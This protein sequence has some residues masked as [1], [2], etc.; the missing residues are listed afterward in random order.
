MSAP[1]LSLQNITY[2]LGGRPLLDGAELGVL[3]GE[4]I[5]LVGRNGSGK[6]T[7]LKIASGDIVADSGSRFVQPGIKVHY[8]AQEPDLSRYATTLDY[9]SEGLDE[10]E[11][12]RARS[13]LAELGMTGD[14]SCQNLSGGEVRRCALARALAAEPDLLL[15]DEPTNH[16]DLPSITWLEKELSASR[17]AMIVISHD[18]RLLETLSRS[19]VWLE[20]GVT[21]RLNQGFSRYETWRDEVL[22]QQERDSHKLDRQIAREEDWMIYGVTARRKRNVRRVGELEALRAQR[23]ELA[24]RGKGTLRMAATD[25]D[26]AGKITIA[27]EGVNWAYD[28]RAIV[29]DLDLRILRG[30]RLGLVGANGAG[31]TTLLRLLTGKMEPQSGTVKMGPSVAMV[32]LD[33]QRESLDPAKTL[34]ETLAG[35]SGDMVQVG[36]EKRHVIGYMKDFLF[37]PE[38]ARTPVGKLSGGERGRLA[39]AC[40]LAKPSSLMVLDEPTNDLDLE[41][42]D[43]LQDMLADYAGTVLLVSHDRDFLD[44]VASSVLVSDG[45][46]DWIEYAGGYSDMLIQRGDVPAGREV[47]S[48]EVEDIAPK[49][50]LK[51]DKKPKKLSYNDKR[52][53]DLLPQKMAELEKKIQSYRDVLADPGLYGRDAAKFEKT[54]QFL[55]AAERDLVQS[56]EQWLEL[57]MKKELL[58]N[59]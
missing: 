41:T 28:D 56:E 54:T 33:Q 49:S 55:E 11:T 16:L 1:I 46:G 7:L 53:L 35:G 58:E 38:Q 52:A 42:L 8:L 40:A 50:A 9:A 57:E 32:T 14:E 51:T 25:A 47:S 22:E 36:D 21:R 20:N 37:R 17:C 43:L 6:S 5:C 31:K 3:P 48:L 13:M 15:L 18:R 59:Q 30:D 19:V 10:T 23:K 44:R 34:A 12:Y 4:R 45:G 27:A 24:S 2:T 39:L 29:R 26:S